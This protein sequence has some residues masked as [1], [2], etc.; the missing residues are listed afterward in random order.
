MLLT[1]ILVFVAVFGAVV[2]A[3]LVIAGTAGTEKK[4]IIERLESLQDSVRRGSR[5]ESVS[6]LR[7]EMLSRIPV[8]NRWLVELDLF[9]QLRK[10]LIQGDVPLTLAGLMASSVALAAVGGV[11]C[12]WR[13]RALP[14]SLV[15]AAAAS[16]PFVYVWFKRYQRFNRFEELLPQAL[17]LM[18][19]ALR[20]GHSL[21]SAME[22]VARE[23][24][25]PVGLEFRK[26]F[27]EQNFGLDM[28]DSLTNLA[29]RMPTH[30]IQ[31]VVTAILIQKETGGNLAEI[32]EKVAH[33]IRERFRLK[34]QIRVH[35]AQGRLTGWILTALP[36]VL[37]ALMYL[38]N[39]VYMSR[40]WN[41]PTGIKLMYAAVAMIILGGLTIRKIIR[42]R[43]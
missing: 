8:I 16:L 6:L 5:E 41:H 29:R 27:D 7:E 30:D 33:I 19:N 20:A 10:V 43:V 18:V 40:L 9:P 11:A 22:M 15:M 13:T 32:L 39:P 24:P 2:L 4:Q 36:V 14:F 38:K 34:R 26:T 21:I 1:A 37:G 42:I 12:Y 35:T 23:V 25:E 17:D 3:A 28:R 31:I